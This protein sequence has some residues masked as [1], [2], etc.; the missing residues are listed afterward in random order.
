[1]SA[2]DALPLL[3]RGV[4]EMIQRD[5]LAQR[6][7]AGEMLT[8]KAGFDPT[9]P[10]LHL[11]HMLLLNKLSQF[12]Q[13]GHR[14]VF[15][16][17]D[18]TAMVGDPS[19]RNSMRPALTQEQVLHNA[20][21]Y[22]Q[23]VFTILDAERTDVR[24]NSEWLS[25]LGTEGMLKLAAS[26]TVARIL[27]RDDFQQRYRDGTPIAIH[28]FLYPLMQGH[29]SVALHADVELGGTDQKFNLLVGRDLQ[30]QAGQRPQVVMT[31][32]LLEGLGG[33]A[34]MSKSLDNHVGLTDS[35]DEMF[36]KLM[37]VSDE[38]MWRYYEL[39]STRG[40]SVLE[41]LE[42]QVV[43]GRNPRDIKL[44]LASEIVG[45]FHS[46]AVAVSAQERF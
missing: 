25:T 39:L 29:D 8:V 31:L 19:G 38:L 26:Y 12:Q 23:Q 11:G 20:E 3:E 30:R 9:A 46:R 22:N 5:E 44:E 13:L 43:E 2:A 40:S 42:E 34:K 41:E 17:G 10:D 6:L 16:I 28:E 45:R 4:Q 7:D 35:P 37:S 15:L 21:T 24:F 14:V 33:G 32:P 1:M 18:F 27:E 36:G